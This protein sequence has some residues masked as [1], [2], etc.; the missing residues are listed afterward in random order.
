MRRAPITSGLT[1]RASPNGLTAKRLNLPGQ[2]LALA[3]FIVKEST[4]W[5]DLRPR[6]SGAELVSELQRRKG[7]QFD[8]GLG[9]VA[10]A[11]LPTA[12]VRTVFVNQV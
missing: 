9:Q 2:V 7:G 1:V 12:G 3:E 6:M 5:G 10:K 8:P 4:G 11:L